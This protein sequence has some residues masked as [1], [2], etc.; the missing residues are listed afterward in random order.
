M[1]ITVTNEHVARAWVA[2]EMTPV[3]FALEE[4]FAPS[5]YSDFLRV[6]DEE[7]T[8]LHVDGTESVFATPPEAIEADRAFNAC[9][10]E[11][12]PLEGVTFELGEP[13]EVRPWT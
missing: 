5:N 4:A 7:I 11:S 1:R 3:G 6:D 12:L 9:R 8:V 13:V 2:L 10:R